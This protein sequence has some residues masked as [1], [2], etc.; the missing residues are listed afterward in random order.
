M[1]TYEKAQQLKDAGFPQN[2]EGK[3]VHDE[4]AMDEGIGTDDAYAPTPKEL[5]EELGDAFGVVGRTKSGWYAK[6]RSETIITNGSDADEALANLYI[7]LAK[8][9]G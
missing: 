7:A 3:Y 8:I 2:G 9:W 1:I 4:Q 5:I 6:D